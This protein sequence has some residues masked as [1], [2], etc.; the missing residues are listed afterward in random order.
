MWLLPRNGWS[1][2]V[3]DAAVV[4][5]L[6]VPNVTTADATRVPITNERGTTADRRR[7]AR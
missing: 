6:A 1:A 2:R 7:G 3:N 4:A 5:A